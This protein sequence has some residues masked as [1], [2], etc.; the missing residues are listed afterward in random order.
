MAEV[1]AGYCLANGQQTPFFPFI[2][3]VREWFPIAA[4]D[5]DA[6]VVKKLATGLDALAR[7]S[8]ENIA[9]LLQLV[10]LKPDEA[11]LAGLDAVLI[12]LRTSD[13]LRILL[14]TRC[15]SVATVLL[16]EDLQ[17]IDSVS[18][19]LVSRIVTG[20]GTLPL[21]VVTTRRPEYG[22]S[23]RNCSGATTLDVAPLVA[24]DLVSLASERLGTGSP[25]A[26]LLTQLLERTSGNALF[27]EENLSLW[28]DQGLLK[29]SEGEVQ[30][31]AKTAAA[32]L[33]F[34]IQDLLAAR[35][36]R[37]AADDRALLQAAAVIGRRFDLALLAA[38]TGDDDA[39][40]RLS[41]IAASD[42]I[43]PAAN[44]EDWT[45]KHALVR[46]ALYESLLG[47]PRE[48]L[49]L[50]VAEE[51]ERR[52]GNRLADEVETLALHFA[53][54]KSRDKAFLYGSMAA[55]K[56]LAVYSLEEASGHFARCDALLD[57]HPQ[58]A[59]DEQVTKLLVD[60]AAFLA[61]TLQLNVLIEK[62]EKH[63]ER[64]ENS[65]DSIHHAIVLHEYALAL[66]RSGQFGKA[67][68]CERRLEALADRLDNEARA[69]ALAVK[70][71]LSTFQSPM[72]FI[73]FETSSRRA[74]E[75]ASTIDD[76]KF[77][78]Y[79][80]FIVAWEYFHWGR[81][82][83]AFGMAD[84]MIAT[85]ETMGDP[86]TI[87]L[88]CYLKAWISLTQDDYRRAREFAAAGVK[89]ARAPFEYEGCRE[90][91]MLADVLLR[92][93]GA[94]ETLRRVRDDYLAKGWYWHLV[95]AEGVYGV[96]LA[97][98]GRLSEGLSILDETISSLKTQ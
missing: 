89:V 19:Q 57:S 7:N 92:E 41:R 3:L 26:Q 23:W 10:G 34:S 48:A 76:P 42:L 9:L 86:R 5:S 98:Q 2:A 54:T 28:R 52:S 50:A 51:I 55:A 61:L 37:L 20:D 16:L 58:I 85:G 32:K 69:Y 80:R 40:A 29:V 17:W 97:L 66:T 35:V 77:Q 83:K 73:E 96:G 25:P 81:Q 91:V 11:A 88:G 30:F 60:Y 68:H 71:H 44:S 14:E 63:A 74:I 12:A 43:H 1:L 62:V 8:P 22:P 87:G 53:Q 46:D 49:H 82:V 24:D 15:R 75:I 21:L 93:P 18:E 94:F 78:C 72:A 33:P 67:S 45:F 4:G 64:L 36:D 6:E 90:V 13:L 70:I 95:P 27:A 39:E 47:G 79:L 84:E 59:T 56:A 65:G 38:V 31:D